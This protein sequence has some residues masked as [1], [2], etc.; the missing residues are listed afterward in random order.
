MPLL[1]LFT[2]SHTYSNTID[3]QYRFVE[4]TKAYHKKHLNSFRFFPLPNFYISKVSTYFSDH[5]DTTF[6]YLHIAK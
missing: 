2:N 6:N 1:G 5:L 4:V 3:N